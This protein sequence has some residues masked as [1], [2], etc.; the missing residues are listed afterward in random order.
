MPKITANNCEMYY[1]LDDLTAPWRQSDTLWI[2][3]GFAGRI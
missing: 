2:Q 3:H 1:E